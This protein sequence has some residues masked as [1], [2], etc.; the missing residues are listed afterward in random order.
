MRSSN[1]VLHLQGGHLHCIHAEC[2]LLTYLLTYLL[3]F[4]LTY[5]LT[6]LLTYLLTYFKSPGSKGPSHT[7]A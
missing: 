7:L 2:D 4:P 6:N 5:L 1:R 3:T